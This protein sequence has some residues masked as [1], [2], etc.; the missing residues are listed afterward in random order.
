MYSLNVGLPTAAGRLATDL[1]REWPTA[2]ARPRD[3]HTLVCKRLGDGP[4]GRI[5]S[6]VRDA[7]AGTPAFEARIDGVDCFE[8]AATGPSPVLYLSVESPPLTALHDRFCEV[9]DPVEGIEGADYVPHVTVARGGDPETARRLVDREIEPIRWT[10]ES[11]HVYDADR[12]EVTR[13]FSLPA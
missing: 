3:E 5:G 10:V 2:R 13:R 7:L 12:G 6:Q 4:L 11:V 8:T 1:A 9:F